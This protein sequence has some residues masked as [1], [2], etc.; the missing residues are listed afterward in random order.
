MVEQG[1]LYFKIN[2]PEWED[3]YKKLATN[4]VFYAYFTGSVN[5]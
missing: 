4:E 5:T 2:Y 1:Q 3:T